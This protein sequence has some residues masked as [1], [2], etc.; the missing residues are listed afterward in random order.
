MQFIKIQYLGCSEPVVFAAKELARYLQ[1][2]EPALEIALVHAA[3][4]DSAVCGAIWLGRDAAFEDKLPSVSRRDLDDGVYIDVR[5]GGGVITGTNDRSVLLGAYRLLRELGCAWLFPGKGGERIPSGLPAQVDVRVCEAASYRHRGMC[6]EGAVSY[7]HVFNMIEWLPRVGMNSYFNQFRLPFTFFER[8]YTHQDNPELAALP[9][10]KEDVAGMV[11]DHIAEIKKRGMLYHAVG[12]SWTCE[13]FGIEGNTWEAKD[14]HVPQEVIPYLAQVNGTRGLWQ[15]IPLNTNLCYGN[16]EARD[17]MTSAIAGYCREHPAVD[18]VQFWLADAFNNHCECERCKDTDPSDFYVMLLNQLDE[19]LNAQGLKTRIVFLL[20]L[21]LLWAPKRE[22]IKNSDRFVLLFAP[23]SRTYSNAYTDA[24]IDAPAALEPYK[25]NQITLPREVGANVAYLR[26]WQECVSGCDSLIFDYHFMWDHF[27]DPG[28]MDIARVMF[29]DMKNLDKLRLNGMLSCQTQRAFFPT[30]LGTAL[31]AEALWDKNSDYDA[32]VTR[33][34][35]AAYGPGWEKTRDYLDTLTRLF[36]PPYIRHEK[37]QADPQKQRDFS[38]IEGVLDAFAPVINANTG[39]NSDPALRY[40]WNLL[41]LHAAL[42]R[43]LARA[44][45][46]RAAGNMKE[47]EAG[48]EEAAAFARRHEMEL[49]E[50]M[51]VF[52]FL[53]TMKHAVCDVKTP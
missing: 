5:E 6:I 21:E 3:S 40:S 25:R 44:F 13:P 32:A 22:R 52:L 37:P 35:K 53:Q 16:P 38:A 10:S 43:I 8:W 14:Y 39:A 17:K 49:H 7:S 18:Y 41:A 48:Y 51:D 27:K 23:I 47:A 28:Y 45:T 9:V 36:D 33:Y 24:D 31:M 20:Y 1:L 29:K 15:G 26:K 42:C 4:Y 46:M 11:R 30:G 19:K 34:F 50:A 12:H 2:I